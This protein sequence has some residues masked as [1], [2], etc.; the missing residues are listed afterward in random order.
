MMDT[1]AAA[2]SGLLIEAAVISPLS[3]VSILS[4]R[5]LFPSFFRTVA[6][7][8]IETVGLSKLVLHFGWT[9]VGLLATDNDYG[10]QGI[11]P[12]KQQLI[13]SGACV[14][15]TEYIRLGQQD[16][17]APYI[18]K[19]IKKSTV[20]VII[21]FSIGVELV[22]LFDEM[23]KQ[24]VKGKIFVANS[25]WA[26]S[27]ILLLT[28]YVQILSGTIGLTIYNPMVPG[29]NE[30][31]NKI[32]PSKSS[33]NH[34]TTL[35]WENI[36][37]CQ[38]SNSTIIPVNTSFKTCTE[39]E[40]FNDIKDSSAFRATLKFT[41]TFYAAIQFAAKSLQD[42]GSCSMGPVPDGNCPDIW[43]IK[44]WQLI[45]YMKKVQLFLNN[46]SENYFDGNGNPPALY[47]ILNWQKNLQGSMIHIKVGNYNG[48]APSGS[49]IS[50][51]SSL[52]RWAMGDQQGKHRVTKRRAALSNPMFT[53]VT[54]LKVKKTNSTYLPTA[55]C[56]RRCALH[57]S[58]TGCERRSAGKQSRDVTALLSGR[59]AHTDSTGGVQS[60]A[61]GTDSGSVG[62]RKRKKRRTRR[63]T[64]RSC[65]RFAAFF[66]LS[67]TVRYLKVSVS[68]SIGRYPKN[69]GY[70]RYRYPIPIQVN[71]TSSIGR[72]CCTGNVGTLYFL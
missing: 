24:D 67:D 69:I 62:P 51:N 39:E 14:A 68:D 19:V 55:V 6:S 36:F 28:N 10:L 2:G 41:Y 61:P 16:R 72:L 32:R 20:K 9:W 37:S 8:T 42:V 65:V 29:Y 48:G 44:H 33:N 35:F 12:V 27:I 50:I 59:C 49:G 1:V 4:N 23:L 31:L 40:D 53:L 15:F 30:F 71:G 11:L 58:C 43:R 5:V 70:R 38:F 25:G 13:K 60:R 45:R 17:N 66:V 46:D 64:Q 34:W 7:D 63:K 26:M 22:L 56:P 18:A 57:S 21:V 54:I 52:L 3:T 47:S